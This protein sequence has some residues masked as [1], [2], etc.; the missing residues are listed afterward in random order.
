MLISVVLPQ[1]D[2]LDDERLAG[3]D[4]EVQPVQHQRLEFAVAEPQVDAL[5][6]ARRRPGP[7]RL[8]LAAVLLGRRLHDVGEALDLGR[9]G[10][11]FSEIVDQAGDAAV[12]L[13]LVGD[14]G[15]DRAE[16]HLVVDHRLHAEPEDQHAL[17]RAQHAVDGT[18]HQLQTLAA[19]RCIGLVDGEREPFIAATVFLQEQF[20]SAHPADRLHRMRFLAGACDDPLLHRLAIGIFEPLGTRRRPRAI[21]AA[22]RHSF[23]LYSA[24][25][26]SVT[27]DIT[28]SNIDSTNIVL[29]ALA[30]ISVAWNFDTTSPRWR[31]WNQASGSRTRWA[32]APNSSTAG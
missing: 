5:D 29:R 23:Q 10:T 2:G 26:P 20:D 12:E 28:P 18:E 4:L 22:I 19:H 16:R 7:Y 8:G 24:I 13:I 14:E 17:E 15:D 25:R 27:N 9:Q 11:V 30:I 1:P 21:A 31:T 32:P 3:R 6:G